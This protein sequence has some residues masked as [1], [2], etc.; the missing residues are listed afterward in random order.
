M[1]ILREREKKKVGEGEVRYQKHAANVSSSA[2]SEEEC[3]P[4]RTTETSLLGQ[5]EDREEGL[6][7]CVTGVR[8][9]RENATK[10]VIVRYTPMNRP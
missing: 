6:Q 5:K 3:V 4:E 2:A 7:P 1:L 9:L 8:A 10:I